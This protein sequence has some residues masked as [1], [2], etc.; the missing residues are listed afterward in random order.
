MAGKPQYTVKGPDG[1]V[2]ESVAIA[3]KKMKLSRNT[4]YGQIRKYGNLENL[5]KFKSRNRHKNFGRCKPVSL[6]GHEWESRSAL[7]K[8][9]GRNPDY[10]K[11]LIK[12]EGEPA[13]M[14]KIAQ[15]VLGEMMK[16]GM[17]PKRRDL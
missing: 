2:Y 10:V 8:F 11:T 1:K 3:A 9:L 15:M 6:F 12:R 16:R 14:E 7:S 13:A 5:E 4:I 17:P